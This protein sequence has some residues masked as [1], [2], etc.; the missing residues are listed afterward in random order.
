MEKNL[1]GITAPLL[2]ESFRFFNL[3]QRTGVDNAFS[4]PLSVIEGSPGTGKTQTIL[5]IIANAVMN[6][7]SVAVVSSNNSA[8]KN[9]FEKLES[10]G[11]SFIA[12]LLGSSQNA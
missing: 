11:V 10:N 6:N 2:L 5:N 3:S 12:A 9:I 4:N 1:V 8:T 7:Q